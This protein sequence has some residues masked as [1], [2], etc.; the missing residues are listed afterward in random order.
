MYCLFIK[1]KYD[2]YNIVK[3][4]LQEKGGTLII[5]PEK[6]WHSC[7][8]TVFTIINVWLPLFLFIT[9]PLIINGSGR[10]RRIDLRSDCSE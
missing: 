3:Y 10:S 4:E 5:C 6:Q 7:H 1:T 2:D 9:S 8:L